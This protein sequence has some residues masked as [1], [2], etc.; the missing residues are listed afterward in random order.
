MSTLAKVAVPLG[1][2]LALAGLI[3]GWTGYASAPVATAL[4]LWGFFAFA[5]GYGAVMYLRTRQGG[6]RTH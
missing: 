5:A 4:E 6:D 3:L 2:V 1:I